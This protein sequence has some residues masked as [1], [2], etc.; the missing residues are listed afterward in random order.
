[1]VFFGH[2]QNQLVDRSVKA[3]SLS[4]FT[5]GDLDFAHKAVLAKVGLCNLWAI[6]FL[7]SRCQ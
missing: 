3:L 1:M 2:Q 4:V 6:G 5:H 7:A